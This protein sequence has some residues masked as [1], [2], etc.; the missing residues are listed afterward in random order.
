MKFDF[1][2]I[3]N[4]LLLLFFHNFFVSV[5]VFCSN[6]N[7]IIEWFQ[8]NICFSFVTFCSLHLVAIRIIASY[9]NVKKVRTIWLGSFSMYLHHKVVFF[10]FILISVQM[11]KHFSQWMIIRDPTRDDWMRPLCITK[12]FQNKSVAYFGIF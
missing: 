9:G 10:W 7:K 3:L 4:P 12:L 1:E 5:R 6:S 11:T 2:K 8:K